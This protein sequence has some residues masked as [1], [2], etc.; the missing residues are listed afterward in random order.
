[1]CKNVK[2]E[3]HLL[4]IDNE[5]FDLRFKV[6]NPEARPD[7]KVGC[8]W[9]RGV[10]SFFDVRVTQRVNSACNQ[11]KSTES[12]LEEHEKE[13]KRK[14]QQRVIDLE[15]GSFTPLV[16]GMNGG[17]GKECKF[18]LSNLADILSR[19]NSKSYV[20]AISWLRTCIL[21]DIL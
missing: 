2:E 8:F 9:T 3:P 16:F 5:I 6:T 7:I 10:T 18:F 20:S 11:N 14:N 21:F 13:K 15:M 12:I 17:M 1:M 19:K 4:P